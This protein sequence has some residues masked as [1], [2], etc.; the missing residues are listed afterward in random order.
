L[1]TI[2]A[3]LENILA[4]QLEIAAET[5]TSKILPHWALTIL[6]ESDHQNSQKRVYFK[7]ILINQQYTHELC[8]FNRNSFFRC[9]F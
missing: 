9:S 5:L 4:L 7:I 3:K 6:L 1:H 8:D 2:I